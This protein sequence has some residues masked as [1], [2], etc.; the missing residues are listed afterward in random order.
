MASFAIFTFKTLKN[1][2]QVNLLSNVCVNSL[3]SSQRNYSAQAELLAPTNL[4]PLEVLNQKIRNGELFHDEQQIKIAEELQKVFENIE[5]YTPQAE[6]IFTRWFSS[7]QDIPKGLYIHGAVGGGKT[8]L[9]DL[10]YN[11]CDVSVITL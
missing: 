3:K 5:N 8:M 1:V 7:K 4:G 9:M 6:N 10:F 2:K 11:C